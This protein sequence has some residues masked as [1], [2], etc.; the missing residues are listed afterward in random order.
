MDIYKNTRILKYRNR[1]LKFCFLDESIPAIIDTTQFF[2]LSMFFLL[3]YIKE[4][5]KPY[6]IFL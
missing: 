6:N 1:F 4:G 2:V 5:L 3:K